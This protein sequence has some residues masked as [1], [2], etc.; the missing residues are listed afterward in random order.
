VFMFR[1]ARRD[2]ITS[3]N[4]FL[5]DLKKSIIIQ[6]RRSSYIL[7]RLKDIVFIPLTLHMLG[8]FTAN[9]FLAFHTISVT[10][11][12]HNSVTELFI[13]TTFQGL[14]V[15]VLL[16]RLTYLYSLQATHRYYSPH[17]WWNCN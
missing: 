3:L 7:R 5:N 14:I 6:Y 9:Y 13:H 15:I 2:K 17:V 10:E 16:A 8:V 12:L 1:I 11:G 4:A